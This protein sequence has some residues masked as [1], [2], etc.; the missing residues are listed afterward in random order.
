MH[1]HPDGVVMGCGIDVSAAEL[2]VACY[3]GEELQQ[4]TFPN[5]APGHRALV[6]WL[7]KSRAQVRVCVEATGIY[8]LD[9]TLALHAA[10]IELA[11]LNPRAV[12]RFAE[13][14]RR[15]KTDAADAQV[16]AEYARR[17]PFQPWQPP[18]RAALELRA[19]LRH[20]AALRKH[21]TMQR[22]RLRA[23]EASSAVPT[24]VRQ[25]LQRSLRHLEGGLQ[26][27]LR[28]ARHLV[29]QHPE[30]RL[31]FQLLLS[32]PGVA[33]SSALHLLAELSLLPAQ[34]DVR[35]WVAHS[36]LDPRHHRSGSSVD[37]PSRI[38]RAGNRH[39]RHSLYMPALVAV[40]HDPHLR[41]FYQLLLRRRKAKLQALVAVARK[42]LHAI[43]G[44]FRHQQPYDG[45]RL[46]PTLP[47]AP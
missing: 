41:A 18:S 14:L 13:T 16:L 42:L 45:A 3:Q 19:I 37:R 38:S 22:N 32:L 31:R 17:M 9:L 44:I 24:C 35:Q 33:E 40:R 10:G 15:S 1:K 27:L 25:E 4:R 7:Q 47:L 8:S 21:H 43:F 6:R 46:F 28:A 20:R 12:S 39:L 23:A 2:V 30:L 34:L 36:G 29:N 5:R 11:V 26:R